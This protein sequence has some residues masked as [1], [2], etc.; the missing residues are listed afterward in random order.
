MNPYSS[1][2]THA[3]RIYFLRK[4]RELEKIVQQRSKDR[5]RRLAEIIR[6]KHSI[7]DWHYVDPL[8]SIESRDP[9][10]KELLEG[11][12]TRVPIFATARDRDVLMRLLNS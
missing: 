10:D 12:M 1:A 8:G 9:R 6:H 5:M 11:L 3:L 4:V 2:R 7:G